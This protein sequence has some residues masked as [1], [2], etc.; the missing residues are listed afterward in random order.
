MDR[1]GNLEGS[2]FCGRCRLLAAWRFADMAASRLA[3]RTKA[4]NSQIAAVRQPSSRLQ[5]SPDVPG[6]LGL[7]RS[8]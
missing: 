3:G 1:R 6:G 2:E 8:S 7:P 4:L 5:E